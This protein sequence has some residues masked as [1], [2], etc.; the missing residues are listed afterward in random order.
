MS[1]APQE[2]YFSPLPPD[3]EPV[4]MGVEAF[5][6]ALGLDL[7]ASPYSLYSKKYPILSLVKK[8]LDA[9]L[10]AFLEKHASLLK[11]ATDLEPF[12]LSVLLERARINRWPFEIIWGGFFEQRIRRL[13][14]NDIDQGESVGR[15]LERLRV[16]IEVCWFKHPKRVIWGDTKD[17]VVTSSV[18]RSVVTASVRRKGANFQHA[19]CELCWRYSEV[20]DYKRNGGECRFIDISLGGGEKIGIPSREVLKNQK[21]RLRGVS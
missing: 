5:L 16:V 14:D 9:P 11:L 20:E 21:D 18:K 7:S 2:S 10:F 19:F 12:T 17:S 3:S 13:L 8:H 6:E 1:V 4:V 15:T